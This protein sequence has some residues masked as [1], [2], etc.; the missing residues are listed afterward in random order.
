MYPRQED[1]EG[2]RVGL[3]AELE[4][5]YL[6]CIQFRITDR[7]ENEKKWRNIKVL[8]QW[9]ISFSKASPPK[10]PQP[11]QT[12]PASKDNEFKHMCLWGPC[13]I[14]SEK[15]DQKEIAALPPEGASPSP[16]DHMVSLIIYQ[17]LLASFPK[18]KQKCLPFL[19]CNEA[20]R[21]TGVYSMLM[22]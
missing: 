22:L 13:H 12:M 6:A 4:A 3:V 1:M 8:H 11:Y 9:P 18:Q 5:N 17:N 16:N 14:H 19:L 10:F 2:G 21:K 15:C 20:V 7:T